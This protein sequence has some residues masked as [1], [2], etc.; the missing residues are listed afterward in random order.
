MRE[1]L[2]SRRAVPFYV[3][4]AISL[5]MLFSP[6]S[7]VPSGPPWGDEVTH[8]LMF[9]ALAVAA[10]YAGFRTGWILLGGV[11]YAAVTEVLQSVLPIQRGGSVGDWLADVV[12]V[13][14]GLGIVWVWRTRRRA[15][16]GG[17]PR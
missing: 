11:L 6:G 12:G 7:T 17:I 2:T 3:V 15:D 1:A 4:L 14:I 5:V 8:L 10:R 13:A 9:L 16:S